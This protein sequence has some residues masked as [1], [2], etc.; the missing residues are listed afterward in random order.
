MTVARAI[1]SPRLPAEERDPDGQRYRT[2]DAVEAR[3]QKGKQWFGAKVTREY[4]STNTYDLLFD[5]G[6]EESGV[7][8][9]YMKRK[10]G[11]E[12]R[13]V[14]PRARAELESPVASAA[15]RAGDRVEAR[16]RGGEAFH[17]ARIAKV[18][19]DGSLDLHY[20]DGDKESDVA[21]RLVRRAEGRAV[22]TPSR[23]DDGGARQTFAERFNAGDEV[24]ARFK[25]GAQY[26]AA[27]VG[28]RHADGTYDLLY[29]DGDREARVPAALIRPRAAAAARAERRRPPS[30]DSDDGARR[31]RSGSGGRPRSGS[32][33]ARP[34]SGSGDRAPRAS[35]ADGPTELEDKFME[36]GIS[37]ISKEA[38]ADLRAWA[39][40]SRKALVRVFER[41]DERATAREWRRAAKDA[42]LPARLGDALA[43]LLDCCGKNVACLEVLDFISLPPE[44]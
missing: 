44:T 2:G 25:G 17:P 3:F 35:D 39:T 29:D 12:P 40:T 31:P 11:A 34:R 21:P 43:A 37:L 24:E 41:L 28:L 1:I 19:A 14:A 33:G 9:R 8:A 16:F 26:H 10:A 38:R 23:G 30:D 32:D 27:R 15:Y 6:D 7:A 22:S 18:H 20:L 13:I 5:D 36:A 4:R 42:D